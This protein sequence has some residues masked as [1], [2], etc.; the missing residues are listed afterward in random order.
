MCGVFTRQPS[1]TP[2]AIW[3]SFVKNKRRIAGCRDVS[4]IPAAYPFSRDLYISSSA[5]ITC[6]TGSAMPEQRSGQFVVAPIN[7]QDGCSHDCFCRLVSPPPAWGPL[8]DIRS[9]EGLRIQAQHRRR[10]QQALEYSITWFLPDVEQAFEHHHD[11]A[12]PRD[13]ALV[14][15]N[16]RLASSHRSPA[17]RSR[18]IGEQRCHEPGAGSRSCR[19][20]EWSQRAGCPV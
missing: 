15:I 9:S 18:Q 5:D 19:T 13:R 10:G 12:L 11:G 7:L 17:M 14:P 6:V 20:S 16:P 3:E 8:H 1:F 2:S 4:P